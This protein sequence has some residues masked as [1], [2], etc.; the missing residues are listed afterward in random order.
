MPL[1]RVNIAQ[2]IYAPAI[3][4]IKVALL[5]QLGE[6]FVPNRYTSRWWTLSILIACNLIIY[7]VFFFLEIFQCTPREAI[8]DFTVP[9]SCIN[10]RK[11]FISTA[12]VNF[13]DDF[14]ILICPVSWVWG[15]QIQLKKKLA[16]CLVF[17]TGFLYVSYLSPRFPDSDKGSSACVASVMRLVEVISFLGS[18]DITFA[19]S[20]VLWT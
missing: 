3:C 13:V 7:I 9:G 14:V 1:Q 6:I 18:F 11:T 8:W 19:T 4:L 20:P 5:L 15:L 12:A 10:I 16:I 17:A 2:I